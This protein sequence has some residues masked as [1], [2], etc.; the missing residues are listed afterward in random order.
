MPGSEKPSAQSVGPFW[1]QRVSAF[2]IRFRHTLI[3]VRHCLLM[4]VDDMLFF[5]DEPVLALMA[6]LILA[7]CAIFGI[8]I[9]WK[10][11]QLGPSILWIFWIGWTFHF[12]A[13]AFTVPQDKLDRLRVAIDDLLRPRTV[14]RKD[15]QK[16]VGFLQWLVQ[17]FWVAKPWLHCLYKD[18]LWARF[19]VSTLALGSPFATAWMITA[20]CAKG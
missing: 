13:V 10:K 20:S 7:I 5:Q 19:S 6:L 18:V 9:S 2:F 4:Y 1:F 3:Y 11:L 8:P 16:V 12:R 14:S 15:L 17:L